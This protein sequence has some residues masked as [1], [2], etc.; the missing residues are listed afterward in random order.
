[1]VSDEVHEKQLPTC[2]TVFNF[3]QIR[4]FWSA[5]RQLTAVLFTHAH[6]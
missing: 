1:M 2:G 4:S 3:L 5:N 6:K